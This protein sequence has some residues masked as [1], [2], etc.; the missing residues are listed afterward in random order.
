MRLSM[1]IRSL[2]FSLK[3]CIEYGGIDSLQSKNVGYIM[4]LAV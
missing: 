3:L 4:F 2:T 1:L